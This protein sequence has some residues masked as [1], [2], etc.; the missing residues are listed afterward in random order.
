MEIFSD[1]QIP[2]LGLDHCPDIRF[3]FADINVSNVAKN[4]SNL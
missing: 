4:L 3:K 2:Q 1:D